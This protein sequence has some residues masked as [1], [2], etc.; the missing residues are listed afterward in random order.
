M[1]VLMISTDSTVFKH[2]SAT[3]ARMAAY[4]RIVDHLFV[5]VFSK[6]QRRVVELTDRVT[7]Y[8]TRSWSRF[9]Y[10]FGAFRIGRRLM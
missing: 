6:D 5:I 2:G 8:S 3:A 4:G 9:L 1:R 7:V 10:M